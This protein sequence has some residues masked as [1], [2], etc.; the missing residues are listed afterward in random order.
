MS[1]VEISVEEDD[2]K[3]I[4]NIKAS[5]LE[6]VQIVLATSEGVTWRWMW[7]ERAKVVFINRDGSKSSAGP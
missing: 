2:A 3:D 4:A 6:E 7:R 1:G 5:N